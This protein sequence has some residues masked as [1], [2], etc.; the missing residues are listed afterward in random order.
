MPPLYLILTLA[1]AVVIAS[2]AVQHTASATISFLSWHV[3]GMPVSV[4]VIVAVAARRRWRSC[5]ARRTSSP[6][7]SATTAPVST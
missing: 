3:G 4:L 6:R 5:S 2:F 1:F 7:G